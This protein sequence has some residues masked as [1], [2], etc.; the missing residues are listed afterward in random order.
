VIVSCVQP[1]APSVATFEQSYD[2]AVKMRTS[3]CAADSIP[4]F[5]ALIALNPADADVWLNLGLAHFGAG[6][7]SDARAALEQAQSLAPHYSDVE[8][9]LARVLFAQG[10][11]TGADQKLADVL[12]REPANQEARD[13]RDQVRDARS[14]AAVKSLHARMDVLVGYSRLSTGRPWREVDVAV[15]ESLSPQLAISTALEQSQRFG[16]DDTYFAARVDGSQAALG[17]A[18][19]GLGG[20]P[21]AHFRARWVVQAGGESRSF[22]LASSW[23]TTL[24]VDATASSYP[25]EM[26]YALSPFITLQGPYTLAFTAQSINTAS[27]THEDL[28]GYLLRAAWSGDRRLSL[29]AAYADAPEN[30]TGRTMQVKAESLIVGWS[31]SPSLAVKLIGVHETRPN[32]TRDEV[33]VALTKRF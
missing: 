1:P 14:E 19:L 30:D 5:K 21:N 12:S 29:A 31:F 20:A 3:G 9:A 18:Y 15:S 22:P 25:L 7:I 10:D 27:S 23:S 2:S 16:Q 8:I 6:Q 26:I 13:L 28:S 17:S 24:G 4:T 11:L 33:D 32:L